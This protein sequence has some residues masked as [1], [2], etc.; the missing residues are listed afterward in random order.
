MTDITISQKEIAPLIHTIRDKQVIL[1]ADLA[2][3]GRNKSP[4]QGCKEKPKPLS[5]NF[6]L[7][8]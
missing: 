7:S 1:D 6:L 2:L 8:A 5:R 4:K 3:S